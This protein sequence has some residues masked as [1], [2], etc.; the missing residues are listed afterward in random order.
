MIT[1]KAKSRLI[2]VELGEAHINF[3]RQGIPPIT[4]QFALIR[5]DEARAGMVERRAEWS[6]KVMRALGDLQAAM[7]EDMLDHL[8]EAPPPEESSAEPQQV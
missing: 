3:I 4:A 5:E 6:D 1:T 2:G 7:E 8:F